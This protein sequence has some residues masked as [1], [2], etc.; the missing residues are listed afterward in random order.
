MRG[1]SRRLAS[2]GGSGPW[3]LLCALAVACGDAPTRAPREVRAQI[4]SLE[5]VRPE[6]PRSTTAPSRPKTWALLINGGG[7]PAINYQSHLLHVRELVQLLIA[8]GIP[9]QRIVVFASDGSDPEPDLAVRDLQAD[10]DFWL[11]EGLPIGRQLAP[12]LR[13]E[14]SELEDLSIRPA[15][16]EALVNWVEQEGQQL[17]PGD[18]LF[19]YV[20]DHGKRNRKDLHNNSIVLW[21]DELYVDEFKGLIAALP[22]QVRVVSLMSQC[23]SGA[24]ANAMYDLD[25]PDRTSGNV[26]GYYSSS[27]ERPAYGCYPENRGKHNV[28]HSFRFFEALRIHGNLVDAHGRVLLTDRTPDVPNRTSDQFLARILSREAARR[29][30]E[31]ADFIDELL[32]EAMRNEARYTLEFAKIDHMGHAFGSFSP[33]SRRELSQRAREIPGLGKELKSYARRWEVALLDLKRENLRRFL[34]VYPSWKD[35]MNSEFLRAL[36]PDEKRRFTRALLADLVSF[37]RLDLDTSDRLHALKTIAEESK[38]ASYRMDVR[39]GA[40]LRIR[41]LLTRIAGLVYLERGGEAALRS[42]FEGLEAC[43]ALAFAT[44]QDPTSRASALPPP[45]PPLV[46]ESELLENV[47]PGWLGIEFS[48]L[49]PRRRE[50]L[51]LERGAVHVN[52]VIPDSPAAEAGLLEQDIIIGPPEA[53]FVEPHQIREW[54][55]TSV[56]GE[57]RRLVILRQRARMTVVVRVGAAPI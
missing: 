24:F 2:A 22:E 53:A 1:V 31:T 48:P 32:Q 29:G 49:K 5:S 23:Y 34:E 28:G 56:V 4:S 36:E 40:I 51:D 27:R 33:R 41:A 25:E 43:E 13:Y 6:A 14:N 46:E 30:L 10:P 52:K 37:T 17:E 47:L 57:E 50:R 42:E 38:T 44:G 19:I 45:F 16:L 15:T 11:I 55:M 18:T 9:K 54:I 20:T 39:R 7:R 35:E 3:L 8:S 26:C 21:G 12:Q